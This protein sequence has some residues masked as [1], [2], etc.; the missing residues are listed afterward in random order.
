VTSDW[1]PPPPPASEPGVTSNWGP[2]PPPQAAAPPVQGVELAIQPERPGYLF[3]ALTGG[4]LAGLLAAFG[5]C[6][7]GFLSGPLGGALAA[8]GVRRRAASFGYRE[9]A[10]A[11]FLAS[12]VA[13]VVF[14]AIFV[15][16]TLTNSKRIQN[17]GLN[18]AERNAIKMFP[19]VSEQ[20]L[21]DSAAMNAS[22]P[23]LALMVGLNGGILFFMCVLGGA[24]VGLM[25]PRVLQGWTGPPPPPTPGYNHPYGPPAGVPEPYAAPGFDE[26]AS[27]PE[28]EP[29]PR[30]STAWKEV[31]PEE[32]AKPIT[33]EDDEVPASPAPEEES[34]KP[35]EPS[36]PESQEPPEA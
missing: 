11:G 2:P 36:Q 28:A 21:R 30:Y 24:G 20:Q 13:V 1:G 31:S 14:A 10:Y 34:L 35:S 16:M 26:E 19:M 6:I 33:L 17:E 3:P 12:L 23:M 18:E 27:A 4:V 22:P 32:L 8:W 25:F 29:E 5:A 7:C 15:P 9:G